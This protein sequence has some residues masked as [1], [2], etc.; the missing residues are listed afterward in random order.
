MLHSIIIVTVRCFW[1]HVTAS[2]NFIAEFWDSVSATKNPG[3]SAKPRQ[4]F[5]IYDLGIW[6]WNGCHFH[7]NWHENRLK[8]CRWAGEGI[9]SNT[10][11]NKPILTSFFLNFVEVAAIWKIQSPIKKKLTYLSYTLVVSWVMKELRHRFHQC[12]VLLL[13]NKCVEERYV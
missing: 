11:R 10:L 9:N 12:T 4:T 5:V 1:K 8:M 7:K 3:S 2:K 6:N 13:Y